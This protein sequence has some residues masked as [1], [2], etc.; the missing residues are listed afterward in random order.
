MTWKDSLQIGQCLF[1]ARF[2]L[3]L[4]LINTS[5]KKFIMHV[6]QFLVQFSLEF[7]GSRKTEDSVIVVNIESRTQF[8]CVLLVDYPNLASPS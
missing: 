7:A 8:A 1:E 6:E 3:R 5:L 2:S 4:F